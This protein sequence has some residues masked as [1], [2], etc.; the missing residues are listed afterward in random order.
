[1]Q[2]TGRNWQVCIGSCGKDFGF[3]GGVRE[4][5][6]RQTFIEQADAF[7]SAN[8]ILTYQNDFKCYFRFDN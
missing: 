8:V 4:V 5:V 2:N 6:L 7:N 3:T 1:V